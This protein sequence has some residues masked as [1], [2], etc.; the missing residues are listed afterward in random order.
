[1]I[2]KTPLIIHGWNIDPNNIKKM[3]SQIL[4][5]AIEEHNYYELSKGQVIEKWAI[6]EKIGYAK[7]NNPLWHREIELI[8]NVF[9]KRYK[10]QSYIECPPG[11]ARK[12]RDEEYDKDK[13]YTKGIKEI[14]EI[15]E[16][17][18]YGFE[19]YTSLFERNEK[20]YSQGFPLLI[21]DVRVREDWFNNFNV[22]G[23]PL[24]IFKAEKVEDYV[25]YRGYKYKLITLRK[26]NQQEFNKLFW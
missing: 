8:E 25:M 20:A 19:A 12:L 17:K 6:E 26:V 21:D 23:K 14:F 9:N 1:M 24:F 13:D 3:P 2:N 15:E 4:D 7:T 18:L 11:R 22:Q 16:G 10:K 5:L